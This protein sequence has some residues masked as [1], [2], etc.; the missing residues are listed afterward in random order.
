MTNTNYAAKIPSTVQLLKGRNKTSHLAYCYISSFKLFHLFQT[1]VHSYQRLWCSKKKSFE[2]LHFQFNFPHPALA[3]VNSPP[4]E[5]LTCQFPH[6]PGTE[7]SQMPEVLPGGV[8]KFRFDRRIISQRAEGSM[9]RY[10]IF[11]LKL[12]QRS[13]KAFKNDFGYVL[14]IVIDCIPG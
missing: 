3:K 4:R 7:N 5:G 8:L 13:H 9:I 11:I 14:T 12:F 1:R 2:T 6:S 10:T